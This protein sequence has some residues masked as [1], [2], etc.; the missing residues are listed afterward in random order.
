M[1][2]IISFLIILSFLLGNYTAVFAQT[3][4]E[5]EGLQ[6]EIKTISMTVYRSKMDGDN[7]KLLSI[8]QLQKSSFNEAGYMNATEYQMNS[9]SMG[10]GPKRKIVY[11][12]DKDNNVVKETA[13]KNG[14]EGMS[15]L[16]IYKDGQLV[17][18]KYYEGGDQHLGTQ[19]LSYDANGNKL[20]SNSKG[21]DGNSLQKFE[22]TYTKD[23]KLASSKETKGEELVRYTKYEYLSEKEEKTIHIDTEEEKETISSY[24]IDTYDDNK[25][26]LSSIDYTAD[27]KIE[28][29]HLNEYNDQGEITLRQVF[30]AEGNE[31]KYNYM[32]YQYLHDKKGNWIQKVEFLKNGNS[33]DATKREIEYYK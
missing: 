26:L 24:S 4:L 17:E 13:Y 14:T 20:T 18:A 2:T 7:I 23:N 16:Y 11:E 9:L 10:E 6:G 8:S 31:E 3:T 25:N 1:K 33:L 19:Y 28:R 30:D 32:R 29:K 15:T 12:S 5:K 22:F 21:P 27:G